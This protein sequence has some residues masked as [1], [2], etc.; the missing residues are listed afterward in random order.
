MAATNR[1][2]H[3]VRVDLR[4]F[5]H[6]CGKKQK[7]GIQ[8]TAFALKSFTNGSINPAIHTELFNTV[9]FQSSHFRYLKKIT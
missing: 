6:F 5:S 1:R 4:F 9:T 7:L 2:K 3:S 8:K